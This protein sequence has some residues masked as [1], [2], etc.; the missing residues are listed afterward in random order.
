MHLHAD[1]ARTALCWENILVGRP[2]YKL[3]LYKSHGADLIIGDSF[4]ARTWVSLV[5][6]RNGSL[7][8][9]EDHL[10]RLPKLKVKELL[11]TDVNRAR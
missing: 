11:F 4:H 1:R 2:T 3:N 10:Q 8:K 9:D 7:A 5:V 6:P